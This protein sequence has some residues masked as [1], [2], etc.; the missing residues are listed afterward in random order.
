MKAP[1]WIAQWAK[2]ASWSI[3]EAAYLVSGVEPPTPL[4]KPNSKL[5]TAEAGVYVWLTKEFNNG[6]LPP[7]VEG[8][9]IAARFSPGTLMR[10]LKN[11][12]GGKFTVFAPLSIAYDNKGKSQPGPSA[13]NALSRYYYQQAADLVWD[14]CPSA[15]ISSVASLLEPLHK[16]LES[17]GVTCPFRWKALSTIRGYLANRGGNP[18]GG[19]PSKS[20]TAQELPTITSIAKKLIL[21]TEL[22]QETT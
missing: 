7:P 18:K 14:E 3:C 21:K 2:T 20:V 13:D 1:P 19:R 5:P 8:E 9:G 12:G 22:S 17:E 15:T 10:H 11:N 6:H 4:V 16:A